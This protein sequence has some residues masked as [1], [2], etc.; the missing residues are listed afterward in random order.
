MQ[1]LPD[2]PQITQAI[3]Y[4]FPH[5]IGVAAIYGP[6]LG[7]GWAIIH[8]GPNQV[9]AWDGGYAPPF[10]ADSKHVV[11]LVDL[12]EW[13]DRDTI[14]SQAVHQRSGAWL[15]ATAN[16]L[17]PS[18]SFNIH[19]RDILRSWASDGLE[20][21]AGYR[22]VAYFPTTLTHAEALAHASA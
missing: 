15:Q 9:M 6:K 16:E 11:P 8:T 1:T 7:S 20:L 10:D 22:V 17:M 12:P 18:Y 19:A 13:Q 2:L 5:E 4:D 21:P 3:D 14:A